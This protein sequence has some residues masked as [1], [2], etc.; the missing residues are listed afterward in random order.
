MSARGRPPPDPRGRA[1]AGGIDPREERGRILALGALG[2]VQRHEPLERGRH[3]AGGDLGGEPPDRA[4]SGPRP[5]PTSTKY[6]GTGLPPTL[7]ALPWNPIAEMWCCP[8]PFGHPLTLRSRPGAAATSSGCARTWAS[9]R[10][11]RP[12]DCVTASLQLSAPGQLV[13]R[14]AV[15]APLRPSPAAASP[16]W[17]PALLASDPA[18]DEVLLAREPHGPVAV[19]AR[20]IG[21]GAELGGR[22]V[23]EREGHRD[24]DVPGLPLGTDVGTL[25]GGERARRRRE[26]RLHRRHDARPLHVLRADARRDLLAPG[27]RR[28]RALRRQL[29][30]GALGI[31]REP[32]RSLRA[33]P[34]ALRLDLIAEA[35]EPELLDEELHPVRLAV[36]AVA[37]PV[38]HPDHRLRQLQQLSRREERDEH[39]RRDR[40]RRGAAARA[41]EE[42]AA[43]VREA[44]GDEPDRGSTRRDRPGSP[45]RR[46]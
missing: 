14:A 38:E 24:D 36:D 31:E 41:H 30:P 40:E 16:A 11:P 22:D 5:P 4:P 8:Q 27:R 32:R 28:A 20:E 46:P 37:Q 13:T 26:V 35:L 43:A 6:C 21:Q 39:L 19:G 17:A 2:A 7:R 29:F 23:A 25:E 3:P 34:R 44:P 9:R 1:R 15:P 18:R 10:R 33:D 12:R 42:A 45:R